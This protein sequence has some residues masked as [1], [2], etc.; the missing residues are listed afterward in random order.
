MK[1]FFSLVLTSAVLLLFGVGCAKEPTAIQLSPSSLSLT[2]GESAGITAKVLPE[3][4]RYTGITWTSSNAK[5]A[6][7][8]NGRVTAVGAGSATITASTEGVSGTASVTVKAKTVNVT[9]VTLDKTTLELTEGES[10]TLKATV[11]PDN[12]TDKTVTWSSSATGV[13]T[14]DA[15]GKVTAVAAGTATITAKT[16]D[17]GKTATCALTVKS[18][19]VSLQSIAIDPAKIEIVEG[20]TAELK[21]VYTPAD[22]TNKD[23]RWRSTNEAIAT[24]EGGVIKALKEGKAKVF[25]TSVDGDHEAFCEVTVKPDDTLKGIAFNSDKFEVKVGR[26]LQLEV[27]YTPSYAANKKVTFKSSAPSVATVDAEGIV[28]GV[29]EGQTTVTATSEEGGFTATCTVVVSPAVSAGLYYNTEWDI[30]CDGKNTGIRAPFGDCLDPAGNFY[31]ATHSD[32]AWVMDLV[33]NGEAIT[34]FNCQSIDYGVFCAAGGGYYFIPYI[35]S[36]QRYA[37]LFRVSDKGETLTVPLFEGPGSYTCSVEDIAVDA[38]GNAYVVG[39]YVDEYNVRVAVCCK[40]SVDGTVTKTLLT[41]GSKSSNCP[42]VALSASGDVYCLVYEGTSSADGYNLYLYKNGKRQSLLS[43]KVS[44]QPTSYNCDLFVRGNDVYA[45]LT[46]KVKETDEEC[47]TVYKNGSVLYTPQKQTDICCSGIFVASNGD[48]YT[49]GTG[50]NGTAN[51]AYI[52]KNEAVLYFG[53]FRLSRN[54][55]FMKE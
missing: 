41:D 49:Q 22:A 33:K 6:T 8:S 46:E 44:R 42:V 32:E 15:S 7:V 45:G 2:E 29:K 5:V 50:Y 31:Y 21:V 20:K 13:A 16:N 38:S 55:L 12:A 54:T 18:K 39:Y 17:G 9:G 24:V 53:E 27:V 14:V 34:T 30:Y 19:V 52:W 40:V 10:Q 23:V 26:T 35:H 1:Q 11:A 36:Y 28:T 48:V 51:I 25:A 3:D 47:V 4:A 43:D 37:A